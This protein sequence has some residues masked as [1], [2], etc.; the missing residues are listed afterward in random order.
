MTLPAAQQL[1]APQLEQL[2]TSCARLRVDQIYGGEVAQT[3]VL[4]MLL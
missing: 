2:L 3:R 1:T 4:Q